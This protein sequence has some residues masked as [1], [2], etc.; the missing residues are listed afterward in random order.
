MD[1]LI[2]LLRYYLF[3]AN[4]GGH[5]AVRARL[6]T[7]VYMFVCV[8]VSVWL[9]WILAGMIAVQ[10][11]YRGLDEEEEYPITWDGMEGVSRSQ[12]EDILCSSC[13]RYAYPV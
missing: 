5:I 11:Q 1:D 10:S 8:S 7:N 9:S 3:H 12:G 4:V 6:G 2:L 13:L